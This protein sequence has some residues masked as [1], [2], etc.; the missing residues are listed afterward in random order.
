MSTADISR[1][2]FKRIVHNRKY[3][4]GDHL[5]VMHG[6]EFIGFHGLFVEFDGIKVVLESDGTRAT[7]WPGNVQRW[8]DAEE[9][10]LAY[11]NLLQA[12]YAWTE[13]RDATMWW[14]ELHGCGQYG[15]SE[16]NPPGGLVDN[17]GH[18]EPP[19]PSCG[20]IFKR[21]RGRLCSYCGFWTEKLSMNGIRINGTH[22]MPSNDTGPFKGY[23]GHDFKIQMNS[24]EVIHTSNL[25]C[26]GDIPENFRE[27]L[28]DNASFL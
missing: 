25:W 5:V 24:G 7:V 28:P 6:D 9:I 4:P 23:G 12:G 27:R 2:D 19:C 1:T 3:L 21:F 11:W 18:R 22:Y 17:F 20:I 16:L 13:R 26:Q 8:S 14:N 10:K 15:G